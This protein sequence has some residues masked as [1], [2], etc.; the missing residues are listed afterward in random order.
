[1]VLLVGNTDSWQILQLTM[2][3]KHDQTNSFNMLKRLQAAS[4]L[5]NGSPRKGTLQCPEYEE[6]KSYSMPVFDVD[7]YAPCYH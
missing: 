5:E 4:G 7:K 6:L 2:I 1:M 3:R